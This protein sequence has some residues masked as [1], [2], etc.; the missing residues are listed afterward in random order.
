MDLFFCFCAETTSTVWCSCDF[1]SLEELDSKTLQKNTEKYEIPRNSRRTVKNNN[2]QRR[3][4]FHGWSETI[5]KNDPI[6]GTSKW[7][8]YE[9]QRNGKR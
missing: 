7:T 9:E 4:I 3:Q 6:C 5:R 8:E 1:S 2:N